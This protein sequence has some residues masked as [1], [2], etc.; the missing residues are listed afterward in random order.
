M[1]IKTLTLYIVKQKLLSPKM[2]CNGWLCEIA[3]ESYQDSDLRSSRDSE[4]PSSL[5]QPHSTLTVTWLV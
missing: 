3:I 4:K 2:V 1:N 5:N